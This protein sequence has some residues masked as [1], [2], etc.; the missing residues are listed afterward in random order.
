MRVL[1]TRGMKGWEPA[2]VVHEVKRAK[3]GAKEQ[4]GQPPLN[5]SRAEGGRRALGRRDHI[6]QK[7][8]RQGIGLSALPQGGG[9]AG[10][11]EGVQ[12]CQCVAPASGA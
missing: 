12:R 3:E 4:W 7:S 2:G 8:R 6:S 11:A 9:A 1:F 10:E 5:A